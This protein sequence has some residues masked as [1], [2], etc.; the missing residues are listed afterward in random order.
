MIM[1]DGVSMIPGEM[2]MFNTNVRIFYGFSHVEKLTVWFSCMMVPSINSWNTCVC[3][4]I[5]YFPT[6]DD[7]YLLAHLIHSKKILYICYNCNCPVWVSPVDFVGKES[8]IILY[9]LNGLCSSLLA[10]NSNLP[11]VVF[12]HD[13]FYIFR[14]ASLLLRKKITYALANSEGFPTRRLLVCCSWW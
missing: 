3:K 13:S 7:V 4:D 14:R 10:G 5:F 9:T 2:A 8:S 1:F 6:I 11:Y 12:V